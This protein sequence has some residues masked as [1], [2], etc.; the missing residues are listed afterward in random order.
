MKED[1]QPLDLHHDIGALVVHALLQLS[2]RDSAARVEGA[3]GANDVLQQ[4][5][6]VVRVPRGEPVAD[7][8]LNG[9]DELGGAN[10]AVAVAVVVGIVDDS[11]PE[12][13]VVGAGL[14]E[15]VIALD[16]LVVHHGAPDLLAL[17]REESLQLL[18][19]VEAVRVLEVIVDGQ[20]LD[21]LHDE[22]LHLG[23]G[24]D[25]GA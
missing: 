8:P 25:V 24:G 1:E 22:V 2:G 20:G 9:A 3:D 23:G 21:L 15:R 13:G 16:V 17:L 14:G 11:A 5:N 10:N 12:A 7:E 18:V 19:G 4:A 6:P